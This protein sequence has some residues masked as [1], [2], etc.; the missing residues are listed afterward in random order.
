MAAFEEDF[1]QTITGVQWGGGEWLG[2]RISNVN[3][4]GNPSFEINFPAISGG[5]PGYSVMD[6]GVVSSRATPLPITM[7]PL[8]HDLRTDAGAP[9]KGFMGSSHS[10]A[11]MVDTLI[12]MDK[13]HFASSFPVR[14]L[15]FGV[16]AAFA[17]AAWQIY[18]VKHGAIKTGTKFIRGPDFSRT[19]FPTIQAFER[20]TQADV[21]TVYNFIVGR[22][23]GS[24]TRMP[25]FD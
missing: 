22:D 5:T 7:R 24:I 11:D 25:P 10:G 14:I 20:S 16:F 2:V 6:L 18:T 17:Q 23:S 8:S 3:R 15:R 12:R 4:D 21:N 9:L 13:T 1:L 19:P